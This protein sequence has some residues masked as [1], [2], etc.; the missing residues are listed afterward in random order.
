M[1]NTEY[2]CSKSLMSFYIT[3]VEFDNTPELRSFLLQEKRFATCLLE[4]N[5]LFLIMSVTC[6]LRPRFALAAR[7]TGKVTAIRNSRMRDD[8]L[9][10]TLEVLDNPWHTFVFLG[11]SEASETA[12]REKK[13]KK[14]ER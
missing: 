14:K 7:V 4:E 12:L 13:E 10:S 5:I 1:K 6:F 3:C 8:S 2:I 11:L 9:S